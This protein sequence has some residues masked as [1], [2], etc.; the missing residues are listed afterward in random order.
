VTARTARSL[1]IGLLV[2]AGCGDA[3]TPPA[4]ASAPA[5]TTDAAV[6]S[7]APLTVPL[8]TT[9]SE[10]E[11][12]ITA[13][14]SPT[15]SAAVRA[16]FE[17][18]GVTLTVTL[19]DGA[20]PDPI[21]MPLAPVWAP[22]NGRWVA[23]GCGCRVGF[24]VQTFVPPRY[25]PDLV[26]TFDSGALTWN[27]YENGKDGYYYLA[28]ADTPDGLAIHVVGNGA[29]LELIRAVASSVITSGVREAPLWDGRLDVDVATGAISAGGFNT[30]VD[31]RQPVETRTAGGTALMLIGSDDA[32]D[33]TIE[34]S[35][36]PGTDGRT[37]VM[38]TKS[39]LSDDSI[40]AVRY[41][42]ELQQ[43][44]DDTLFR[45]IGGQWAQQCQPDRGH[46]DFTTEL[47]T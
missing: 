2:L 12:L 29:P 16:T 20:V 42:I 10:D 35:E 23:P 3:S 9:T 37:I 28:A 15:A 13:P 40:H 31:T 36:R 18:E 47:C 14:L 33:T 5:H 8:E 6:S 27:V 22:V 45:F 1:A 38:I 43:M 26:E 30:F 21:G 24:A 11:A 7:T 32:P 46:Q 17:V 19:P 41:Q 39:N 4:A 44:P 34:V 25:A